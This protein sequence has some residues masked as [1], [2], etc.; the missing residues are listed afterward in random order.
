MHTVVT[1]KKNIYSDNIKLYI[2]EDLEIGVKN[3]KIYAVL[4]NK[5]LV[6]SQIIA[7]GHNQT[8]EVIIDP[9]FSLKVNGLTGVPGD[10]T[11]ILF[12]ES[13]SQKNICSCGEE[14]EWASL[15]LKCPNCWKVY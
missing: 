1:I 15:A 5:I 3:E 11:Y 2:S 10:P 7:I 6:S 4:E 8:I 14:L 12:V 9:E 13:D